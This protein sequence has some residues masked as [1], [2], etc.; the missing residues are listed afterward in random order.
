MSGQQPDGSKVKTFNILPPGPLFKRRKYTVARF[1]QAAPDFTHGDWQAALE[2]PEGRRKESAK[3]PPSLVLSCVDGGGGGGGVL[4]QL[5]GVPEG[6]ALSSYFVLMKQG[7]D[8][9]ALPVEQVYGFKPVVLHAKKLTL[10]EAEEAMR[11]PQAAAAAAGAAAAASAAQGGAARGR[12]GAFAAAR[13]GGGLGGGGGG[14][15]GLLDRFA[16]KSMR[17]AAKEAAED[18]KRDEAF[19]AVFQPSAAQ[20]AAMADE[21]DRPKVV[22]ADD[23]DYNDYEL[24]GTDDD[25]PA[26]KKGG[27]RGG[28]GRG[29]GGAG[30]KRGDGGGD[31]DGEDADGEGALAE[32]EVPEDIYQGEV[33]ELRPQAPDEAAQWEFEGEPDDDDQS[34]G[35]SDD[36]LED[37]PFTRK[38]L[39]LKAGLAGEED[40][41]EERERSSSDE[42]PPAAAEAEARDRERRFIALKERSER[43]AERIAAGEALDE[44]EEED[45]YVGEGEEDEEELAEGDIDFETLDALETK[46]SMQVTPAQAPLARQR[47]P[48]PGGL[49]VGAAASTSSQQQQ[50]PPRRTPPPGAAARGATPPRSGGASTGPPRR[51]PPPA[52]AAPAAAKRRAE[53]SPPAAGGGGGA[54]GDAAKRQR[55]SPAPAAAA[56]AAAA[57]AGPPAASGVPSEAE[58]VAALSNGALTVQQLVALFKGRLHDGA[59]KQEFKVRMMRVGEMVAAPAGQKGSLVRLKQQR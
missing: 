6:S 23:E 52:A 8:F 30:G 59:S 27:R 22:G 1:Q 3:V 15:L 20:I 19:K 18:A 26:G 37:D 56:A 17:R 49:R 39:G 42:E 58:I 16:P 38:E 29:G 36:G 51:A 40:E 5:R 28:G 10:E 31:G 57:A 25:E 45:Y 13:P 33:D 54:G 46:R 4:E 43:A 48:A 53:A 50:Q 34:Q 41:E 7:A 12:P 24:F 44:D 47:S 2:R 11:N 9:T 32:D 14:E 55:L 35:A 21:M